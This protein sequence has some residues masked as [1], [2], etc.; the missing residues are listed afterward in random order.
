M[1]SRSRWR[2][3]VFVNAS[4]ALPSNGRR[5][6]PLVLLVVTSLNPVKCRNQPNLFPEMESPKLL[7]TESIGG[8]NPTMVFEAN[9]LDDFCMESFLGQKSVITFVCLERLIPENQLQCGAVD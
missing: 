3:F 8:Y 9:F 7:S 1:V 6:K 5:K 4:L 2:T